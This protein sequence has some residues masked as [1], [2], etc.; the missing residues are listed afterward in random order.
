VKPI[1]SFRTLVMTALG[2]WVASTAGL[3]V[4]AESGEEIAIPDTP[5]AIWQSIDE[6][7]KALDD[8]LASGELEEVHLYAFA[9]RDLV[10]A[11]PEHSQGLGPK[12]LEQV[13]ANVGYVETLATR[14]DEAGDSNDP[15]STKANLEKLKHILVRIRAYYP[16]ATQ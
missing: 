9:V 7:V 10:R 1:C 6:Q 15:V 12:T 5:A 13:K 14:L 8:L 3:A 16:G 2:A 4:A 11:L